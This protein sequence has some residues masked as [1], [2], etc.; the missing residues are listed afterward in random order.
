MVRKKGK[1]TTP[2]PEMPQ[3]ELDAFIEA[4]PVRKL[5]DEEEPKIETVDP[6]EYRPQKFT[7]AEAIHLIAGYESE[8]L[9]QEQRYALLVGEEAALPFRTNAWLAERLSEWT[10]REGLLVVSTVDCPPRFRVSADSRV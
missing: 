8:H 6:E 3:D 1:L 2:E 7:R 4:K 5:W 9:T 10:G